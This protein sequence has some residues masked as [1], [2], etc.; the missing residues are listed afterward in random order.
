ML[1]RETIVVGFQVLTAVTK[2]RLSLVQRHFGATYCLHLHPERLRKASN[3]WLVWESLET[4]KYTVWEKS[5]I[6][7][8][9]K[10]VV[11][12]VTTGL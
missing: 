3:S 12:I 8:T 7:I 6:C 10:E 9:L 2:S 11:H 4:H 1:F 5:D